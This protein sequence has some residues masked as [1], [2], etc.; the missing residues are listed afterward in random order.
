LAICLPLLLA[1]GPSLSIELPV[2]WK[3]ESA[4]ATA[5]QL[6]VEFKGAVAGRLVTF[7][8]LLPATAYS[9]RIALADGAVLQGVDLSWHSP[10]AARNDA[11]PLDDDDRKQ[12][13]AIVKDVQGF[14]NKKDILLLSGNHDRAVALVQLIRDSGFHSDKGGELIWRIELWYFKNQHGGWEKV[15]QTNKVLRRERF[16]AKQQFEQAMKIKWMPGL[17]GITLGQDETRKLTTTMPEKKAP[18]K[19]TQQGEEHD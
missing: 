15:P 14:E 7:A 2:E 3:A 12:I 5:A 4:T 9:V 18:A 13:T 6:K 10:E 8:N 1:A 16:T 17:G 11:G 19:E